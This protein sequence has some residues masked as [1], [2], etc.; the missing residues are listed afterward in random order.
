MNLYEKIVTLYPELKSEDF[1]LRGVIQL[2]ND[3]EGDYIKE[4][5]HLTL[6]KPNVEQLENLI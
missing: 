1:G 5:N 4:W 2:Q 3:G 6:T